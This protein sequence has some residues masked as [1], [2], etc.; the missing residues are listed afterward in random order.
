VEE[1]RSR[2]RVLACGRRWGKTKYITRRMMETGIRGQYYGYFAPNYK[3]MTEVYKEAKARLAPIIASQN[4]TEGRL[5]LYT[6]GV[7]EFWTLENPDAG[8]SRKYHRIGIDEAGLVS[9]LQDRWNEAIRPTLTDYKGEAD[10]SGTPKGM[11]FFHSLFT[12]GLDP[13]YANWASF[14]MP[15]KTNPYIDGDEIELA[16]LDMPERAYRQEYLAEFLEDGG[17][18][19]RNVRESVR[20]P[21]VGQPGR[22]TTVTLGVDLAR[23]Q[24]FTVICGLDSSGRQVH[25]ERFSGHGWRKQVAMIIAAAQRFPGCLI[26]VD[27]T[28]VGEPIYDALAARWPFVDPYTFTNRSKRELIDSL[29]ILLENDALQLA[30]IAVQTSELLSYEYQLTPQKRLVTTNAPEG[31]HDD[32][33]I[34]L[35]LAAWSLRSDTLMP[36]LEDAL[37]LL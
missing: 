7:I 14:Q 27:S 20:L 28:G 16:R 36:S 15:T 30:D 17:G 23:T 4:K 1:C 11:N 34:G 6:G 26:R 19:F 3:L 21:E 18:V 9:A 25:F 35:A 31:M 8:R 29:A 2:F 12:R 37:L 32:C 22:K 33:V 10:F 13:E 24:D 5:E